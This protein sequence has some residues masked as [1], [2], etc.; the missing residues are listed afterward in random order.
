MTGMVNIHGN[1]SENDEVVISAKLG[2]HLWSKT[3]DGCV[4]VCVREDIDIAI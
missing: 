2:H 3:I 1:G 4:G